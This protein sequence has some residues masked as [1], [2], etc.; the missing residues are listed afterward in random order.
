MQK[1]AKQWNG[2]LIEDWGGYQSIEW[3]SFCRCFKNAL[4]RNGYGYEIKGEN[5]FKP[6]HYCLSGFVAKG[7]AH[8]YISFDY[9]RGLPVNLSKRSWAGPILWRR[10][11]DT[12]DY[13]G[14]I[15]H[16]STAENLVDE[17]EADFEARC[18]EV[19]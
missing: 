12:K 18:R 8:Y 15:N 16:F 14:G 4:K 5:S 10:A 2:K 3:K 7:D 9:D 1:F 6:G 11:K 17:I 13:H 19:A